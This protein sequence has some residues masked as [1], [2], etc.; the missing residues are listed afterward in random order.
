MFAL[1]RERVRWSWGRDSWRI[2]ER[3][4]AAYCLF[5]EIGL[6]FFSIRV[7]S[8]FVREMGRRDAYAGLKEV[9]FSNTATNQL[10]SFKKGGT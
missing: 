8:H 9:I 1:T 10:M 2:M 3:I 7:R 5:W 4:S 6:S